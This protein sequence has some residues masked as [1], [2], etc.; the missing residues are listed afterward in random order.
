MRIVNIPAQKLE[1]GARVV[2]NPKL[3][4]FRGD[5]VQHSLA[6]DA[7][8]LPGWIDRRW[9][10]LWRDSPADAAT[11]LATLSLRD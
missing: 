3:D 6:M 7:D 4:H 5:G 1:E 10:G 9:T 11:D 8:R 2:L